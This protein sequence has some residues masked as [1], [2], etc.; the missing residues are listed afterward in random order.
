MFTQNTGSANHGSYVAVGP[1]L[2]QWNSPP[3]KRKEVCLSSRCFPWFLPV[4]LPAAIGNGVSPS[5]LSRDC[6]F[7]WLGAKVSVK[8]F[9][10]AVKSPGKL[11]LQPCAP[12]KSIGSDAVIRHCLTSRC[13]SFVAVIIIS[14]KLGASL[15]TEQ[16][17][18]IMCKT[19]V[20]LHYTTSPEVH[21]HAQMLLLGVCFQS[22]TL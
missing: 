17:T 6:Q 16:A 10:Q 15:F 2:A 18:T 11:C 8:P 3:C 12:W 19:K 1:R 22:S 9:S 13:H 14:N 20:R 7:S 4:I 5:A 21:G